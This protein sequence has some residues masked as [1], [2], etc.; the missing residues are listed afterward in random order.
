MAPTLRDYQLTDLE[1]VRAIIRRGGRRILFV[2][3]VSYGK[4]AVFSHIAHSYAARGKRV[5]ILAHRTRL[6]GQAIERVGFSELIT[7]STI[8]GVARRLERIPAP[9]VVI[10]DEAHRGGA[11]AQYR[12]V[13]DAFPDAL[14]LGFT[15]TPTP[16][17][18]SVFPV[19]DMV[20]G[21]TA[22]TLTARGFL[23]PV[24]YYCPSVVDLRGVRTVAGEYDPASL[25][26]ALEK[27]SIAGDAI[28]SYREHCAGRPTILFAVNVSHGL[29][30]QR[31][32]TAAG[33]HA[34][35]ITG[36][37]KE[38]EQERK[39]AHL[40]AGGLLIAI[41][42]ISEGFSF[43]ELHAIISMRPT[44]ST[45][46]WIQHVGRV[47]RAAPGKAFDLVLDHACNTLRHGTITDC[48]DWRAVDQPPPKDQVTAE[49][50]LFRIRQCEQCY[51]IAEA[52]PACCPACGAPFGKERRI[53]FQEKV[54]LEEIAA[55][56]LRR[57][58]EEMARAKRR[59][60]GQAQSLASLLDLEKQRGYRPGWARA[61]WAAR[62][63]RAG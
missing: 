58:R 33:I 26:E 47:A 11:G 51:F 29:S 8:Q 6:V 24:R 14:V 16:D 21:E 38:T 18:F 39:L 56:E 1:K 63:R 49:G 4:T 5:L 23:A 36:K 40:Y 3:T 10:V 30:I 52:G 62:Q 41:D 2:A 20:E 55:A 46:L 32:F 31:E 19:E 35:V 45:A 15:G 48:R 57:R 44:R 22:A 50:E 54:R 7:I 42:T 13:Y 27:S 25:V 9:D 59:E 60:E 61:R 28:Q 12:S 34:E 17:L 37:D 43:E 53:S